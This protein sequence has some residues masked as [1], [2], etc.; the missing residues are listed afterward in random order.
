[1]SLSKRWNAMPVSLRAVIPQDG[2]IEVSLQGQ[3]DVAPHDH[4]LIFDAVATTCRENQCSRV[5]LDRTVVEG[6]AKD[7]VQQLV[8]EHV[9]KTFPRAVRIALLIPESISL[10]R[11][12]AAVASRGNIGFLRIFRD[13]DQAVEW[14]LNN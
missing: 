10:H 13:R 6:T 7:V 1:M 5:L 3:A 14:L 2:Y 12:E 9:A 11:F 8:G 4:Q